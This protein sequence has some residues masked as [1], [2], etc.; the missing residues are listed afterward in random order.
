MSG[1][2]HPRT[3]PHFCSISTKTSRW[4]SEYVSACSGVGKGAP[5]SSRRGQ[6]GSGVRYAPG[7]KPRLHC[8][9]RGVGGT[10]GRVECGLHPKRESGLT[11]Q[12]SPPALSFPLPRSRQLATEL[13]FS[14]RA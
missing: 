3:R 14:I 13:M 11:T 1:R 12:P 7:A 2:T 5:G 10:Y 4:P 6:V 9:L 8:R